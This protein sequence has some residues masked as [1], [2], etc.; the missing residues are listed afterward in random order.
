M[1]QVIVLVITLFISTFTW[2]CGNHVDFSTPHIHDHEALL[3]AAAQPNLEAP[4]TINLSDIFD[5]VLIKTDS[6]EETVEHQHSK[7]DKHHH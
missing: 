4:K 7:E 3:L 6:V 2:S 1:R 5:G